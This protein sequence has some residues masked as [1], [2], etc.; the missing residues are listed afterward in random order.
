M[1]FY[2]NNYTVLKGLTFLWIPNPDLHWSN[3]EFLQNCWYSKKK[4]ALVLQIDCF[5]NVQDLVLRNE[6][7]T[8]S[9]LIN[10]SHAVFLDYRWHSG[11]GYSQNAYAHRWLYPDKSNRSRCVRR[12]AV[13]QTQFNAKSLCHEVAQQIWDGTWNIYETLIVIHSHWTKNQIISWCR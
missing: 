11:S 3:A 13:S 2:S 12:G 6:Q 8:T 1:F 4:I 5:E 10:Y 9:S 7:S